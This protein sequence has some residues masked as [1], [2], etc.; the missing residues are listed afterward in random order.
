MTS[1]SS[2][3]SWRWVKV[4]ETGKPLAGLRSV[5]LVYEHRHV[6]PRGAV[7]RL[8][9]VVD[10]EAGRGPE[11]TD[12]VRGLPEP[13]GVVDDDVALGALEDER[14]DLRVRQKRQLGARRRAQSFDRRLEACMARSGQGRVLLFRGM[15]G[16]DIGRR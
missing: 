7:H 6:Q 1:R 3:I 11:G 16:S 14:S 12:L 9:A 15:A 13:G 5:A 10:H 8:V 2:S 4:P